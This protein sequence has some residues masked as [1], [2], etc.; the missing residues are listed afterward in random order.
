[1]VGCKAGRGVT[2]R[3]RSG[4]L[5]GRATTEGESPVREMSATPYR[6]A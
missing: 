5:L 2:K 4:T 6:G 1:M 3:G